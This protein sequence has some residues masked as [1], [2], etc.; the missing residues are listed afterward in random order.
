MPKITRTFSIVTST[1][2]TATFQIIFMRWNSSY[3]RRCTGTQFISA[4]CMSAHTHTHIPVMNIGLEIW[5][6]HG[7]KW[8]GK[9][10]RPRCIVYTCGQQ[11][12]LSPHTL[13]LSSK[14]KEIFAVCEFVHCLGAKQNVHVCLS[15]RLCQPDHSVS[16]TLA[17]NKLLVCNYSCHLK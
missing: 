7:P 13:P 4:Q 6:C 12:I 16:H 9:A 11:E 2:G 8:R 10:T 1:A 5:M 17:Q 14:A 15:A 3:T